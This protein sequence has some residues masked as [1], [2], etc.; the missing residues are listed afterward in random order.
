MTRF[1]S[2]TYNEKPMGGNGSKSAGRGLRTA[3]KKEREV[4]GLPPGSAAPPAV[5]KSILIIDDDSTTRHIVRHFLEKEGFGVLSA[6]DGE[7]G[8]RLAGSAPQALIL[9]DLMLPSMSGFQVL[10]RIKQD[11]ALA[12]VPVFVISSLIQEDV[13]MKAL[14][15]GAVD[16]ITKPFSPIVLVAKIKILLAGHP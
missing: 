7:E 4:C 14:A 1:A 3:R 6:G 5:P 12:H 10:A 16:Y 15:L 13:I 2:R 9:L 8:L 11:A